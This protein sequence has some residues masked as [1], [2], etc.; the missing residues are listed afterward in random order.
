MQ[1]EFNAKKVP[2]IPT[3][4]IVVENSPQFTAVPEQK[5]DIT[6]NYRRVM[7]QHIFKF[8]RS[9]YNRINNDQDIVTMVEEFEVS[10]FGESNNKSEYRDNV[11]RQLERQVETVILET[12][13]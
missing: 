8:V 12:L 10:A 6:S 2:N 5:L 7:Q 11:I 3:E 9:L 1:A 13:F 4:E